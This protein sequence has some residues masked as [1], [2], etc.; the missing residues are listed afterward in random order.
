MSNNQKE[1][2][3]ANVEG[4]DGRIE[5]HLGD[6]AAFLAMAGHTCRFS[7]LSYGKTG[8]AVFLLHYARQVR[9][10][11]FRNTALELLADEK[12]TV[13][14]DS[15][16]SYPSGL[17]G[18]GAGI[19]YLVRQG[20]LPV[21]SDGITDEID[22]I[23]AERVSKHKLYLSTQELTGMQRYMTVRMENPLT[24]KQVFYEKTMRD[25]LSLLALHNSSPVMLDSLPEL[26]LSPDDPMN[27]GLEGRAGKGLM[28]LTALNPQHGTFREIVL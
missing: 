27:L 20:F 6:M 2:K 26:K 4:S 24:A 10:D 5:R 19:A 1:N 11:F 22:T 18:I 13:R 25:I 8:I 7:G 15:G 21:E 9:D 12:K 14:F 17:S 3:T 23:I 16:L 28:L